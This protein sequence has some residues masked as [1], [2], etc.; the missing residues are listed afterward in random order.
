M[1]LKR[2]H[3][4]GQLRKSDCG[5]EITL[6]GWV[7]TYRDHGGLV[8]IDLRDRYGLTQA[9]FNP[10]ENAELHAQA[11]KLRPED[12]ISVKGTVRGRPD[13]MVNPKLPTGEI[14]VT[15]TDLE[16]LSKAK[17][18]PFSVSSAEET[19]PELKLKHR[20]IDLRRTAMQKNFILRHRMF[21]SIRDFLASEDFIDVETP[22]L[23]KS[24]PEG[25]RDYLVPSRVY[26]GKF[27]ALPQSPQMFKQILMCSG[28]DKYSQ[29]TKCFRDEDLRAER[30]PEFT[31]LDLEMSFVDQDDILDLI[32]R[33]MVSVFREVMDTEIPAP[34][35]RMTY[36]GAGIASAGGG[37]S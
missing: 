23:T 3:N 12:V 15:A 18:P 11:E 30:Q 20:Y 27:Y 26:P 25:A 13:G 10:E 6:S 31:Q 8:F 36:A 29:I 37:V 33:L 1:K 24:T 9:V 19:S 35:Q 2:T 14:E 7:D 5:S 4:C 16:I 21:K 17:T 22:V 28:F 32:E 34:F